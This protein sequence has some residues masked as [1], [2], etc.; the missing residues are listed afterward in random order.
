[1]TVK[2]HELRKQTK[3]QLAEQLKDLK[4]EL[5]TLRVQKQKEANATKLAKMYS[6]P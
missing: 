2:A 3:A 1:M 5:Q 4:E 6:S